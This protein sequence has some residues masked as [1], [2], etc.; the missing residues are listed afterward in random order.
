VRDVA[1][2]ST[3]ER[4]TTAECWGLLQ[5]TRLG[6]LAAMHPDGGP[7]VFPVNYVAHEGALY[8]R[9]ARDRKLSHIA[10]HPAVAFE[11]DGDTDS[12][13]WS[14]VVRGSAERLTDDEELGASGVRSLTTSSPTLK[15]FVIKL[16]AHTVSGRRFLKGSGSTGALLAVDV[17]RQPAKKPAKISRSRAERPQPIPHN[18]PL[19]HATA[20]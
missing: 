8:I 14:V 17:T 13:Y 4:L 7:D 1:T 10:R 5:A 16:T 12:A 20:D 19:P 3:V 9:T 6:R 2:N 11:I 15:L 18:P